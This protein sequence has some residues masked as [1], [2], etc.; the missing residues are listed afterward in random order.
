MKV[1]NEELLLRA[2]AGDENAYNELFRINDRF[3]YYVAKKY[4][5][6]GH[7]DDLLSIAR[8]GMVKAYRTYDC[9][10]RVK[11]ITFASTVMNNEI[12][13]YGR[14]TKNIK[15]EMPLQTIIHID[16]QGQPLY[17][18]D[19][20]ADEINIEDII[21]DKDISNRVLEVLDTL[22]SRDQIMIRGLYFEGKTQ[23]QVA[24]ELEL[25]QSY[26]SRRSRRALLQMRKKLIKYL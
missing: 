18:E 6:Y 10:K 5:N 1:T 14:K 11:F 25:T 12:L 7:I 20:L 15:R 21:C 9:S 26:I 19:R 3:C 4:P 17:L 24:R 13:M 8:V 22:S 16:P 2:R 23:R